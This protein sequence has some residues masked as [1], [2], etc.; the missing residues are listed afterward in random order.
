MSEEGECGSSCGRGVGI[1][2]EGNDGEGDGM[3][4]YKKEGS[5]KEKNSQKCGKILKWMCW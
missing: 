2:E 1:G 3:E 5:S 4:C